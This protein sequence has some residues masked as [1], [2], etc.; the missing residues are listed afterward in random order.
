[1]GPDFPPPPPSLMATQEQEKYAK[2]QEEKMDQMT[3]QWE[4]QNKA[5][6]K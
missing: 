1:M 3:S 6:T 2:R 4:K 5:T